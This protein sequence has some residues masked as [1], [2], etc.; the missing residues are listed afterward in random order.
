[1]RCINLSNSTL[2]YLGVLLIVITLVLICCASSARAYVDECLALGNGV[3]EGKYRYE[4]KLTIMNLS[5]TNVTI[6]V[7]YPY[8]IRIEKVNATHVRVIGGRV[9]EAETAITSDNWNVL[10]LIH[11]WFGSNVTNTF[12]LFATKSIDVII[13]KNELPLLNSVL[14]V[15]IIRETDGGCSE[16]KLESYRFTAVRYIIE[17]Q[18]EAIYDCK[19]GILLYYAEEAFTHSTIGKDRVL[20]KRGLTVELLATNILSKIGEPFIE[21]SAS[22]PI[23][24]HLNT[25]IYALV[26]VT[27]VLIAIIAYTLFKMRGVI[28][29]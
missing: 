2:K 16:Y 8:Y 11:L 10:C 5:G 22:A 21:G 29:K 17:P 19:S 15:P 27:A 6:T 24:E 4:I 7:T 13:R 20:I 3:W 14:R 12:N 26:G 1:M 23:L 9:G 25:L 28:R 18:G